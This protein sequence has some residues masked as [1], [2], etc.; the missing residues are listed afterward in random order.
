MLLRLC[1][2]LAL[3]ASTA[4]CAD[5]DLVVQKVHFNPVMLPKQ[6]D[7]VVAECARDKIC[8][9]VIKYTAWTVGINPT[10]VS[11]ALTIA[12]SSQRKPG[13]E[14]ITTTLQFPSGYVYCKTMLE[15]KSVV[16]AEGDRAS[17]FKLF[18]QNDQVRLWAWTPRRGVPDGRS[19]VDAHAT[20]VGVKADQAQ[21]YRSQNKCSAPAANGLSYYCK[22]KPCSRAIS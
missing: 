12:A 10:F 21:A 6:I 9:G 19:W 7:D 17:Q 14:E 11:I 3:I 1:L 16:P 18:T 20:V 22:G 2:P 4:A 8:S 5:D 15:M 13:S